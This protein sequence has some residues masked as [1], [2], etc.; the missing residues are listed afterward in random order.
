M[1][2]EETVIKF[3]FPSPDLFSKTMSE[4]TVKAEFGSFS[5]NQIKLALLL[6]FDEAIALGG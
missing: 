3:T 5:M 4:K 1:P 6:I 2:N